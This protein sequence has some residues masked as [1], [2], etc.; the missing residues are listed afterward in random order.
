MKHVGIRYAG[1]P[2]A[3]ELLLFDEIAIYCLGSARHKVSPQDNAS[4]AYLANRGIVGNVTKFIQD[5]EARRVFNLAP[6][7]IM[8]G[9][10][11]LIALF[12]NPSS[13][14]PVPWPSEGEKERK[15]RV[16]DDALEAF[17]VLPC[18]YAVERTPGYQPATIVRSSTAL[19]EREGLSSVL[20]VVMRQLPVPAPETPIEA[21]V[22]FRADEDARVALQRLRHWMNTVVRKTT[23]PHEIEEE[24]LTL[25][26]QYQEHMRLHKMKHQTGVLRTLITVP[27]DVLEELVPLKFSSALDAALAFRERKLALTEAEMQAPGRNVAYI[28]RAQDAFAQP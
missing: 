1:L 14:P 17:G 7:H 22:D 18:R 11:Q 9:L 8:G 4:I 10:G 20:E 15:V 6:E 19:P 21:I 12:Q 27:L 5:A 24:I 3:A 13:T 16:L 26:D 2:T 25:N 28:V 23:K